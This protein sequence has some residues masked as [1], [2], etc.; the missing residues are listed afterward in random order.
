[1]SEAIETVAKLRERFPDSVLGYET[2]AAG[3]SV[4]TLRAK[5]LIPAAR[6]LRD[7][8]HYNYLVDVTAVDRLKLGMKPRFATIYQLHSMEKHDKR[9]RLRVPIPDDSNP[10]VD[11]VVGVW[12]TANW[13]EREA[14]DMFGI[15]FNG[16][17]DLRRILMPHDWVGHPL[18]KDYP[19]GGPRGGDYGQ[20][21]I[22]FKIN[23]DD[24]EF[25]DLGRQVVEVGEPYSVPPKKA[26]TNRYMVINMGPQHPATHGVLRVIAE[27]DGERVV[28]LY[29]DIGYLHSGFEKTGENKRYKD[30]IPYTDRMDYLSAMSNNLGYVLAVEKLLGI[31]VPERARVIR[32]ILVELQRIASHLMWLGTHVLDISGTIHALLMYAFREREMI[33][34]IFELVCGARLTTAY[35]RFGG[36]SKDVPPRFARDVEAFLDIFPKRLADYRAMLDDNPIWKGRTAGIGKI[37]QEEAIAMGVTG[38]I[39]RAT[40]IPYDIRRVRPYCGYENYDFEIPTETEGDI[41][42]RYLVRMREME[43]SVRIIRQALDRLPEGPVLT[44]DYKVAYPPREEIDRNMEALIHHF[45]IATQGAV[46]PPG[47]VYQ[48]IA[49][50]KGELGFYVISDGSPKPYRLRVRGPSF[51]NLQALDI[52]GRGELFSDVIAI[53]GSID[54]V[55]GEVDR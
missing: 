35:F 22:P 46:V 26:D 50:P 52:M 32:V 2:D 14:Y 11:S 18:R 48:T 12:P 38:P 4:V 47:E 42:A 53:V 28:A 8:L 40:G 33:L 16:H 34:D 43:Q 25:R 37:T 55:L 9:V 30:F 41:Y 45:K 31:E 36:L 1:M 27:L 17:P 54:I 23:W 19:L 21:H 15:R 24:D 29:P 5:D 6:F 51:V 44:D 13:H 39:L 49:A 7:D 20:E 3:E 10:Q